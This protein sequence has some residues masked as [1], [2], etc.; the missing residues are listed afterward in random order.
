MTQFLDLGAPTGRAGF[1]LDR[2]DFLVPAVEADVMHC[3]APRFDVRVFDTELGVPEAREALDVSLSTLR[4][5]NNY[6]TH[7]TVQPPRSGHIVIE[8]PVQVARC[9]DGTAA[10]ADLVVRTS[11]NLAEVARRP[12]DG[13]VFTLAQRPID[14]SVADLLRAAALDPDTA[15]ALTLLVRHEGQ[16]C[17]SRI[18]GNRR[19]LEAPVLLAQLTLQIAPAVTTATWHGD[20]GVQTT[21]QVLLRGVRRDPSL[22]TLSSELVGETLNANLSYTVNVSVPRGTALT[23]GLSLPLGTGVSSITGG[24]SALVSRSTVARTGSCATERVDRSELELLPDALSVQGIGLQVGGGGEITVA[25][26][27]LIGTARLQGTGSRS[28]TF[29]VGCGTSFRDFDEAFGPE[30]VGGPNVRI[31]GQSMTTVADLSASEFEGRRVI[32]SNGFNSPA[33]C[34]TFVLAHLGG[35]LDTRLNDSERLIECAATTTVSWS[36]RRD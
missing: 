10:E 2:A 17:V 1:F 21:V 8:G 35:L 19:V 18:D 4:D 6:V 28:G 24:G 3:T 32:D 12:H 22:A 31:I 7:T 33:E 15:T 34:R 11:N 23:A 30:V 5:F 29:T 16:G 26:A 27:G 25:D 13:T 36:L 9:P 14:L 20:I